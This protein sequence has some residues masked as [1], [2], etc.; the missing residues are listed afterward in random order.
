M[1]DLLLGRPVRDVDL[2]LDGDARRLRGRARGAAR[3]RLHRP[4]AIRHL[5]AGACRRRA[6]RRRRDAPRSLRRRRRS[7]RGR[8]G[9]VDRGG[10]RAAATSPSTRWRSSFAAGNAS[11]RPLRRAE[12]PRTPPDPLPAPR[13]ARGRSDAGP[14][15]GAVRRPARVPNRARGAPPDRRGDRGRRLRRRLRRPVAARARPH[16][17]GR[18]PGEGAAPSREPRRSTARSRR[19][20]RAPRPERATRGW[21]A[22]PADPARAGSATFSPGW[23]LLRRARSVGSPIGCRS[24]AASARRSS[25]AAGAPATVS[26]GLASLAPSRRR[27]LVARSRRRTRPGRRGAARPRDARAVLD[28]FAA[29]DRAALGISGADLVSP[30]I[31]PGPAIGRALA[32]DARGPRGREDRAGRGARLRAGRRPSAG[33]ARARLRRGPRGGPGDAHADARRRDR[34]SA[35][36]G[37]GSPTRATTVSRS[38]ATARSSGRRAGGT[39]TRSSE[40]ASATR[41]SRSTA[42]SS[43]GR[44]SGRSRP[45]GAPG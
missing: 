32:A 24:P 45:T 22:V 38:F 6:P 33:E 16:P 25:L 9:R 5:H 39:R 19:R 41:S 10:P 27:R 40:T 23:R 7:A 28:A 15:G 4:S 20:W 8:V 31:A 36:S 1:R 14:A 17:L 2:A 35:P 37:S 12:G 26:A 43:P 34:P 3:R 30:R 29:R 18:G 21:R 42:S 13:L 11:D 44:T